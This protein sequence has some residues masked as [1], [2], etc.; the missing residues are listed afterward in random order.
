MTYIIEEVFLSGETTILKKVHTMEAVHKLL[1]EITNNNYGMNDY[2][3][4][5][6]AKIL[7]YH[8]LD[9]ERNFNVHLIEDK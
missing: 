3:I 1:S 8:T 7:R 5:S 6:F 9:N 2:K 4:N